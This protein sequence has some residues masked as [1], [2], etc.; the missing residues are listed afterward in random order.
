MSTSRETTADPGKLTSTVDV[1]GSTLR[2]VLAGEADATAAATLEQLL[3]RVHARA[4]EEKLREVLLDVRKVPF[5]TSLCLTKL[6]A[7]VGKIQELAPNDA[8]RVRLRSDERL[9]WQRKSLHALRC[10]AV[11]L[12]TIEADGATRS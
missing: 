3:G 12:I 2:V 11:D 9:L 8:Y 7:W 4:T 5:M 1:E 6:I 10:F